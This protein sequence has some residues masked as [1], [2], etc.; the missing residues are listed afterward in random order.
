MKITKGQL[1]QILN[2]VEPDPQLLSRIVVD[3]MKRLP[4]AYSWQLAQQLYLEYY[5][6]GDV[7]TLT[8]N[9]TGVVRKFTGAK[10]I[11]IYLKSLGY[12]CSL[13]SIR[14]AIKDRRPNYCNHTF[15]TKEKEI[16]YLE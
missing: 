14:R 10:D 8:N 1:L 6:D 4:Q 12:D 3:T 5:W 11:Y 15:D 16:T 7:I 2:T 13:E 9:I